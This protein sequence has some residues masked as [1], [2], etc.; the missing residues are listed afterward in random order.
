MAADPGPGTGGGRIGNEPPV[1][2]SFTGNLATADN[3]G[4]VSETFEG[5]LSDVNGEGDFAR[6]TIS[7]AMTGPAAATFRRTVLGSDLTP[8][9]EP[10]AF[11]ADGWKVWDETPRDGI[12]R[13]KARYTYPVG[14]PPGDYSFAS[15]LTTAGGINVL[16]PVDATTVVVFSYVEIPSMPVD[17]AGAPVDAPWGSWEVPPG[18]RNVASLNYVKL[19]NTGQKAAAVVVLDFTQDALVG[20]TDANYSIPLGANVEFAWFED[21]TP[22]AT[23]PS[24]GTFGAWSSNVEGSVTVTFTGV[25]NVIYVTYRLKVLPAVLASQSYA[26][27]FTATEI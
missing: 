11:G 5:V 24:E 7:I 23:A 9:S 8:S 13:F 25:G 15:S 14:T 2:T 10:P 27:S 21:A 1:I 3:S 6:A 4:T 26:A 18:A 16:G 12:L 19:R 20:T 17:A 22:A